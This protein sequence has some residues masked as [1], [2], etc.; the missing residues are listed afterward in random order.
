MDWT[1]I[2]NVFASGIFVGSYFVFAGTKYFCEKVPKK[3]YG[4]IIIAILIVFNSINFLV[5]DNIWKTAVSYMSVFVA[6]ILLFN[7]QIIQCALASFLAYVPI[8][9]GEVSFIAVLS[10]FKLMG[11]DIN[12]P[13]LSGDAFTNLVIVL[14]AVVYVFLIYK[15]VHK[16]IV[17]IKSHNKISLIF[18][19]LLLLTA[20][21]AL[22]YKLYF[23]KYKV[24][25]YLVF[26]LILV[27]TLTYIAI[28]VIKQQYDKTKLSDEY[29]KYVEYSKKSEKL[30]D[31]YSINQHENKN[32]LIIIRSMVSKNNKQLLA[33]LDEIISIK[34]NIDDAWIRYLRY[35]PFGG[36]KG[37]IHNKISEMKDNN[38]DV[39]LSISKDIEISGLKS[40]TIKQNTQL[41][42]IIGVFLDNAR[43]AALLSNGKKVSID[44]YMKNKEVVFEIA[45]SCITDVD[46]DSIYNAG[47]STKGSGRGYGLALVETILNENKIFKNEFKKENDYF[48]QTLKIKNH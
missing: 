14:F 30:V 11:I 33:Y 1:L 5:I 8:A 34:D 18:T 24:D 6:Y 29:E 19:F 31:Q 25:N 3:L 20:I 40:L 42:K 28:V 17:K 12:V 16:T 48:V 36:L 2:L 26:N 35:L 15:I 44:V 32:E 4:F 46:I 37:I 39:F 41:S 7:K 38:I 27:L 45:N 22:F 47:T 13:S 43:E 23:H 21:C 10:L 9:L